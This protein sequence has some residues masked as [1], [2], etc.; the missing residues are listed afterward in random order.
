MNNYAEAEKDFSSVIMMYPED[1]KAYVNLGLLF[2]I[3]GN[4]KR[5]L[6]FSKRL[7]ILIRTTSK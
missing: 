7:W 6:T 4:N 2:K 3:S 1:I 5:R